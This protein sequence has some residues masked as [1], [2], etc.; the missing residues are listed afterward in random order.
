MDQ[1][2][3][4]EGKRSEGKCKAPASGHGKLRPRYRPV[5]P[6]GISSHQAFCP[7]YRRTSRHVVEGG[8]R[9]HSFFEGSFQDHRERRPV[10]LGHHYTRV[11]LFSDRSPYK[12]IVTASLTPFAIQV[13]FLVTT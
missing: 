5:Q 8:A 10:L 4:S 13:N 9:F 12:K 11:A 7:C 1:D 2:N 6:R 3:R